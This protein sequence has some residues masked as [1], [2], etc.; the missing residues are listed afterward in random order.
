LALVA[1]KEVYGR[2][3]TA[4]GP[5]VREVSP[6][7]DAVR[8]RF[9]AGGADE[10]V[11]L[12]TAPGTGLE[13]AGGDKK[14]FPATTRLEEG[15]LVLEATPVKAPQWVRYAWH[16]NPDVTLFNSSGL[17]AAPFELAVPFSKK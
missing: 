14:F 2:D 10:K 1:L 5:R 16:D 13:L 9:D 8:I 17:P 4:H 6:E 15:S 12:K 11:V 3:L 7:G